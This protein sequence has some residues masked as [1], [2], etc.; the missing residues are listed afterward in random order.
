LAEKE[1]KV[2]ERHLSLSE[3]TDVLDI[4]ERTAYR[5]IKSGKLRAYKPGRDYRIPESAIRELMERSEAYPKDLSPRL[6]LEERG[7]ELGVWAAYLTHLAEHFEDL[8]DEEV[9]LCRGEGRA[10]VAPAVAGDALAAMEVL[11]AGAR[12]GAVSGDVRA[13]LRAGFRL[14]KAAD[15]IE[16]PFRPPAPRQGPLQITPEERERLGQMITEARFRKIVEGLELSARD[17][18]EIFA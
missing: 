8:A 9:E 1:D 18:E 12:V 4:S 5:W 3:T 11:V 16:A 14:A 2:E 13:L 6:P 7:A 15:N 10:D 17:R